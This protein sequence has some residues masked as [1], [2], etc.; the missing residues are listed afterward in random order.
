[1][2]V[3]DITVLNTANWT[4]DHSLFV[5]MQN[6]GEPYAAPCPV[7]VIEHSEGI[8][9]YDTG[10]S[11]EMKQNPEN[12][13]QF[14]APHLS[15]LVSALDMTEADQLPNLLEDNGFSTDDI[16][17]VILSHLHTDHAG[18]IDAFPDSEIIVQKDELQ[19]AWWP[20]PA[21]RFFY[22]EG[23]FAPLRSPE[24]DVRTV[25]GKCDL[26]GD[27]SVMTLPTPGHSPGHQSLK[28]EVDNIGTVILASDI[29]NLR[30]GYESGFAASFN[31]SLEETLDSIRS[32]REQATREDAEVIIHHDQ[33]DLDRLK[34]L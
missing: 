4:L 26:F 10:V 18:N 21:Q 11:Y 1:M 15:E 8:V 34:S 24:Y 9:L 19:Y 23:D 2:S 7:Y 25:S 3:S 13:G 5:Q 6:F 14:G 32:I 17:H 20:D 31:W 22:L 28:L 30:E 16:D 33:N 27:G 12:Y 29:A